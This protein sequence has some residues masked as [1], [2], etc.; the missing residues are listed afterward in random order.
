M[1]LLGKDSLDPEGL[2]GQTKEGTFID[3]G[4]KD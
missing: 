2:C 1:S 4:L 3:S